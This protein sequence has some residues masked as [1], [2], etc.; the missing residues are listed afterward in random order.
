M[1]MNIPGTSVKMIGVNGLNGTKKVYAGQLSNFYFGTDMLGDE[2]KF[3]FWYSQDNREFR[4]AVEFNAG[5]QVAY[6]NEIVKYL[7]A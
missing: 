5:V 2:E 7:G 1:E 3:E 4:L 6:P